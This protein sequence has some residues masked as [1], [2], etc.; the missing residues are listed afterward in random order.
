MRL[1]SAHARHVLERVPRSHEDHGQRRR[2]LERQVARNAADIAAARQRLRGKAEHREAKHAV[3]RCDVRHPRADG[4]DDTAHF[5]A[6]D[7]R[8]RRFAGIKSERLEHVAEVHARG[9]DF[10]QHLDRVRRRAARTARSAACRDGRA[11]GTQG[12][13]AP[14]DRATARR[15]DVRGR[16]VA[17]SGLR[18]GRRFRARRR[19]EQ[20]R[21]RATSASDV[22]GH[23]RQI[24]PTAGEIR[25]F[26]ED[27]RSNPMPGA[28]ATVVA[29]SDHGPPV[30]L[31]A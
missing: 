7:A 9:F 31:R 29:A 19:C 1:A 22:G 8:I 4:L 24:D 23:R 10:D 15:T 2:F 11:R 3:S 25:V 26:V 14:R 5:V 12:A 30:G 18:H 20:I 17:R 16:G 27:T 28:C 21:S 6:E 13:T